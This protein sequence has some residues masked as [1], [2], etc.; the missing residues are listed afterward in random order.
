M[1]VCSTVAPVPSSS[2]AAGR[3][4]KSPATAAATGG[5]SI[6]SSAPWDDD[7]D[8]YDDEHYP[9]TTATTSSNSNT[10][11]V[12]RTQPKSSATSSSS[13]S[14]QPQA[15]KSRMTSQ[16]NETITLLP[17]SKNELVTVYPTSSRGNPHLHPDS[18][19]TQRAFPV[20][21][22]VGGVSSSKLLAVIL[23]Q[24]D[25]LNLNRDAPAAAPP[26]AKK[27]SSKPKKEYVPAYR[28]G[29]YAILIALYHPS[30]YN[31]IYKSKQDI[32]RSAQAHCDSSFEIPSHQGGKGGFY[33]AWSSMVTLER[34]D[35]VGRHGHPPRFSLTD[36]GWDLAVRLS[37]VGSSIDAVG[38]DDDD[39]EE[40][41]S[42]NIDIGHGFGDG[43][44]VDGC[45][46]MEDVLSGG[47]VVRNSRHQSV[48]RLDQLGTPLTSSSSLSSTSSSQLVHS[49]KR[50]AFSPFHYSY[51]NEQDRR[52]EEKG[53]A[54]VDIGGKNDSYGFKLG[55][56]WKYLIHTK[57][58]SLFRKILVSISRL[59]S[60]SRKI[61]ILSLVLLSRSDPWA[62]LFVDF[63]ETMMPW[64]S[65]LVFHLN[66]PVSDQALCIFMLIRVHKITLVLFRSLQ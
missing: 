39:E 50:T 6:S 47:E 26:P 32:I 22:A 8:G 52:V 16:M 41:M 66:I 59:N 5:T 62:T 63:F 51:L 44:G 45:D 25:H 38:N 2:A 37:R 1:E 55:L 43:S 65:R 14:Q 28:S 57:T 4:G 12:K 42:E 49:N 13:T 46:E 31:K 3:R 33:N 56:A 53:K 19:V 7:S 40:D 11:T 29:P 48:E 23:P 15:K 27:S 17:P 54:F 20:A 9:P 61:L 30:K 24:D 10:T 64:S 18:I 60:T 34:R 36:E 58:F 35:L 21:T